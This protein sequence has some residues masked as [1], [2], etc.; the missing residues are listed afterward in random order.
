MFLNYRGIS[1]VFFSL[2]PTQ[3]YREH[4]AGRSGT[5]LPHVTANKIRD[6]EIPFIVYLPVAKGPAGNSCDGPAMVLR[7]LSCIYKIQL[8][9]P[10]HSFPRDVLTHRKYMDWVR[11]PDTD[12]ELNNFIIWLFCFIRCG[13]LLFIRR[14][15]T[16]YTHTYT[17]MLPS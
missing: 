11:K 7:F 16:L 4:S 1:Q 17:K 10:L 9:S 13:C 3:N 2:S 5:L 14:I 6:Y 8:F 12:I 15:F